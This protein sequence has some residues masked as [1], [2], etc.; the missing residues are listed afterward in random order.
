MAQTLRPSG[1]HSL[2]ILGF[3]T[4]IFVNFESTVFPAIYTSF[5]TT[6]VQKNLITDFFNQL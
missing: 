3:S 1:S 2:T 6:N 5:S 4:K